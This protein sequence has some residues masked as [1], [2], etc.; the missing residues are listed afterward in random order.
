MGF[1]HDIIYGFVN[2]IFSLDKYVL[3]QN[4]ISFFIQ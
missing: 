3:L 2:Q 1:D 4:I